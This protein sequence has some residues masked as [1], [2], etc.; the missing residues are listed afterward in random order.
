ML[1]PPLPPREDTAASTNQDSKFVQRRM[2][3]LQKFISDVV[4]NPYL[5]GDEAIISFVSVQQEKELEKAK[6]AASRTNIFNEPYIGCIAWREYLLNNPAPDNIDRVVLDLRK[7]LDFIEKSYNAALAASRRFSIKAGE[8]SREVAMLKDAFKDVL[9]QETIAADPTKVEANNSYGQEMVP[10]VTGLTENIDKWSLTTAQRP[11]IYENV[12]R[13]TLEFQLYQITAFRELLDYRELSK[14]ELTA[15]NKVML[16]QKLK[17][18]Q[19]KEAASS[20]FGK[21]KDINEVIREAEE[22]VKGKTLFLSVLSNALNWSEIFRFNE[23]R[24]LQFKQMVTLMSTAEN[25]FSSALVEIW[26]ASMETHGAEVEAA[27]AEIKF[28]V[29]EFES[30]TAGG[31]VDDVESV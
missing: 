8:Y 7:Q 20:M 25:T 27:L 6:A 31:A 9:A 29:P 14:K 19:G 16:T 26:R 5:R 30:G 24:L 13:P 23:T 3:T 1:I 2:R 18:E 12:V 22:D 17:R 4:A 21:A 15:A 11:S 10:M 28:L